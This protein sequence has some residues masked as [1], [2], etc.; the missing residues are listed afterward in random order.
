MRSR[1]LFR[2]LM[3]TGFALAMM[4]AFAGAQVIEPPANVYCQSSLLNF[5]RGQAVSL[6]FTNVDRVARDVSMNIVDA[7]GR[8]VWGANWRVQPGQSVSLVG[9]YNDVSPRS[10][11]WRLPVRGLVVVAAPTD[12]D[13][14]P[15]EPDLS[16]ATM[17]IYDE[18]SGKTTF[19]LLLPAVRNARV[20]FPTD[21]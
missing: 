21:Q 16:L 15:P 3:F 17:D 5:T 13:V 18:T 14:Q 9:R 6:N 12:T 4:P 7:T 19:G 20:F 10:A 2:M 8:R 1:Y 11:S